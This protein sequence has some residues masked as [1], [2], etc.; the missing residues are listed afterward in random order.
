M[1]QKIM[2]HVVIVMAPTGSGKG[3][4]IRAGLKAFPMI[5]IAVSCTTRAMR[6]GEINGRE[7]YFISNAEF[8]EKILNEEFL[9]WANFGLNRYGTLKKEII[10]FLERG[11]VVI[12]EIDVQGVEQL[13]KLLPKENSTTVYIEAGGWEK[14]KAR[15]LERAEI[16]ETELAKRYERYLIEIASKD[17]A[18]IIIDNTGNGSAVAE[19]EFISVLENIF[20]KIK[21]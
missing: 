15:A 9:E 17:I 19:K 5:H 18:D 16:S 3:T 21:K 11:D 10:P 7:Y 2:G 4:I 20:T 14:L 12:A 8:D 1:T 6:P 13:H